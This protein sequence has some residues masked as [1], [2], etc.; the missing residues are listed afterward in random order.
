[1]VVLNDP[2]TGI[3]FAML[4]GGPITAERTA[5]VSGVAVRHFGPGPAAST[6]EIHVAIVGAGVQGRA[7]LP[8]FGGVLPGCTIHVFDRSPERAQALAALAGETAGVREAVI[9]TSPRAAVEAADV[10]MTAA[11]FGPKQE[12][13]SMTNAW[14]RPNATVVPV[15][16]ATYCAAEVA[17][18]AALFLVDQREQFVANRDAGNFDDYPDPAATIGE[19]IIAGTARP[20]GRVVVAHLGVGLADLVFADAIVRGAIAAGRGTSLP[21]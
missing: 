3:P 6:G 12:R 15:D 18:D 7:H 8:V 2:E 16:Y 1:V 21:R 14:L 5:A 20:S 9:E 10:I 19:A 11:S 13:Q 17:R 4:D